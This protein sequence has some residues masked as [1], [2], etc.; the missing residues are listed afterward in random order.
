LNIFCKF[1]VKSDDER[2]CGTALFILIAS[3]S[4]LN[5]NT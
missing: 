3:S 2:P 5:L 1:F 4:V